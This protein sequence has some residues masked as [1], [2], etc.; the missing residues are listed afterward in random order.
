MT[1]FLQVSGENITSLQ[2]GENYIQ[3][4]NSIIP[5]SKLGFAFW[6][7]RMKTNEVKFGDCPTFIMY[8]RVKQRQ[9][10]NSILTMKDDNGA[11]VDDLNKIEEMILTSIQS[12]YNLSQGDNKGE[13]IDLLLRQ[14]DI[15]QLLEEGKIWLNREF[16]DNLPCS[17]SPGLDGVTIEACNLISEYQHAFI[18]RRYMEDNVILSHELIHLINSKKGS[19]FTAVKI[20]MSK[21]Y[22]RVDWLFF[23][24]V[25][26]AYGFSNHWIRMISQCVSTVSFKTVINRKVL[27]HFA[28]KCGLRQGDP[29]SPYLFIFC[30][31]I[32]SRMLS[33]A[34]EINQ[35]RGLKVLRSSPSISHLFFADDAMLFF[36]ADKESCSCIFDILQRFGKASGQQLNLQK[37]MIKFSPGVEND[38]ILE[39]KQALSMPITD[40]MGIHL[41]VPIDIKGKKGPLFQ[42]LVDIV[43]EKIIAWASLQLSQPAKLILINTVLISMSAHVMKCL[44]IPQSIVN[45]IDSIIT[46]F[47]WAKCGKKGLHW[48]RKGIT[49]L[50]KSMGG[51]GIRGSSNYNGALIFK[52][53]TRMHLNPQLLLS[54]VYK[55]F[56]IRSPNGTD[57]IYGKRGNPSLGRSSIQKVS[58]IFKEG[59]AWKVG[60]GN[61]IS[62]INSP[63]VKGEIPVVRSN[64]SLRAAL[65]WK[66]SDF[67]NRDTN[68]WNARKV[69]ESF[70]W[71]YAKSI[72]S[73]ELPQANEDDFL[74]WK[75]HPSGKYTVKTGYY[76]LLK[77]LGMKSARFSEKDQHFIKLIWRL[78]IQPKWKLFL[79]KI[80]HDNIVVKVNLARRGMAIDTECDH[81]RAGKEDGQ[82]LFRLCSQVREVWENSLL[83]ICHDFS[84]SISVQKWIQHYILLFYSEDGKN[85]S[86]IVLFIAT[87]W[88]LWKTRNERVY[89]GEDGTLNGTLEGINLA[90]KDYETFANRDCVTDG[91]EV[92]SDYDIDVPPGFNYA[93]LGKGKTGFDN[94]I[95]EVDGSWEKNTGRAGIGWAVKHNTHGHVLGEG[96]NQ[97]AAMSAF[98]CEAWACLEALKWA[99]DKGENGILI[100]SDSSL[101]INNLKGKTGNEI[102]TTWII[103]EIK[104]AGA[105]FQR[106]AVLKVPREQGEPIQ[107]IIFTKDVDN[108]IGKLQEGSMYCFKMV[109][110]IQADDWLRIFHNPY[111]VNI[112]K[113]TELSYVDTD[114]EEF[115]KYSYNL[116]SLHG[117]KSYKRTEGIVIDVAGI[118]I[119]ASEIHRNDCTGTIKQDIILLDQSLAQQENVQDFALRI[120]E[121]PS[122][123][124][125]Y[126]LPTASQVAAMIVG[127][128][129]V[130][131]LNP[132]DILVQSTYGQL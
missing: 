94:F 32:L 87:L 54:R 102:A 76:F 47:W 36:K 59:F 74:H 9:A 90:I 125:Q 117:V 80:F 78:G 19:N 12:T 30:M 17:K 120:N 4:S 7:Q 88:C 128:E 109:Q 15:P 99:K 119:Y 5:E 85:S 31:D 65:D 27:G 97:R 62:A 49:Q 113:E 98:Q 83:N 22:D 13:E 72:L 46:R 116:V 132:R 67:I 35:F 129:E 91:T 69:R 10:R 41:G 104:E 55:G 75:F 105:N 126:C 42:F 45:K 61:S 28:P 81:C 2:E 118:I 70:E 16:S 71:D 58:K 66:V 110:V 73:M 44:K 122:D 108:F 11:W 111:Q 64:Q 63:W 33:L 103:K 121:Q 21:A 34:E 8:R 115:P 48:V 93:Q 131:N 124:P 40:N 127:G 92:S 18:P 23:L 84:E 39:V 26:R 1:K 6:R 89:R 77:D 43:V 14:L 130:A 112:T 101:L 29:L 68:S 3:C 95:M 96:G 56:M 86:R 107:G 57:S 53:A 51:L 25:L 114:I 60:N 37:S 100:F 24:K 123:R 106:C 38:K 79:W 52:Q 20:D 50:P 82:H